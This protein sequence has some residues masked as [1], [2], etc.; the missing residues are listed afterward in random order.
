MRSRAELFDESAARK[1]GPPEPTDGLDPVKRQKLGAVAPPVAPAPKLIIPPLAPGPHTTAELFTITD[2]KGLQQFDVGNIPE[3]L[4]LKIVVTIMKKVDGDLLRQA[5]TGVLDRYKML[6]APPPPPQIP[7]AGPAPVPL[8][9]NTAPLGVEVDEDEDEYEPDFVAAE[10]TEQIL[11][12]LDNAPPEPSPDRAAE[13]TAITTFR[14]PAPEPLTEKEALENGEHTINRVISD[15]KEMTKAEPVTAIKTQHAGLNRLAGS[16]GDKDAWVTILT[17]LATRSCAGLENQDPEV[18][19]ETGPMKMRLSDTIRERLYMYIFGEDTETDWRLRIDVAV[20]WLNEEW[21]NEKVLSK[22]G[23]PLPVPPQGYDSHYDKWALKILEGM[24]PYLEEKDK[25]L[26]RFLGEIPRV[27]G[28]LLEKVKRL[29]RDPVMVP[30]AVTALLYLVMMKPPSREVAL[31]T[32]E[33]V[34]VECKLS[35][36]ERWRIKANDI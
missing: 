17:R 24:M 13:E 15:L 34:W 25:A 19:M 11:N 35:Q 12:K 27:N 29:C 28:K 31:D 1:R 14:M 10:D 20:S 2:D 36:D 21:Y 5:C 26:T 9:P 33:E 18:K 16:M 8:N 6:T 3:D 4:V 32:V 23:L 22:S 7:Q 30:L